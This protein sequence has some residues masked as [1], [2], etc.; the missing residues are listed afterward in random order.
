[1]NM[2]P[3]LEGL[4]AVSGFLAIIYGP[5]QH[6]CADLAKQQMFEARDDLFDLVRRGA[7]TPDDATYMRIREWMNALIRYAPMVSLLRIT[8]QQAVSPSATPGVNDPRN[9]VS[10]N[11]PIVR[12]QLFKLIDRCERSIAIMAIVRSPFAWVA[13]LFAVPFVLILLPLIGARRIFTQI[14]RPLAQA[15]ENEAICA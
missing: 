5:W 7:I 15:V 9:M 1:M 12:E 2:I 3:A 8:L 4:I 13:A 10:S 11:N 6:A 14:V